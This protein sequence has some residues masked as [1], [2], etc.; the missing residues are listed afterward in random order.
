MTAPAEV[1]PRRGRDG[2]AAVREDC[3]AMRRRGGRIPAARGPR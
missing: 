2:A 1:K 3:E